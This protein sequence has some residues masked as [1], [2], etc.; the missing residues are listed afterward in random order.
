MPSWVAACAPIRRGTSLTSRTI[1][2]TRPEPG[3]GS[4]AAELARAGHRPILAPFLTVRACRV[5]LPAAAGLQAVVAASGNATAL[6]HS[7]R[8]LPLLA[9]GDATAARARA[10][11]FAVV[12]SA[13]GDAT[14]L[15]ALAARLLR[16]EQGPILLATGRGQG[17]RL[18]A[19]LRHNG[20]TVHRRAVYCA[21]A[22]GRFPPTV[23]DAIREG[24]DV[25]LF[26]S[27]ETARAFAHL[28]PT[29]LRE[30][31][32]RTD[33]VAIG[34]AAADELQHLPWRALRVALRPTQDEVLALL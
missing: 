31:L 6:P 32:G 18:A 2:V 26:F 21:S 20:F 29:G 13:D 25:A 11:G 27:A 5:R 19:A 23:R 14:A 8:A 7:H 1:L 3:G 12:H 10:A 4:T 22:I 9:V 34:P 33:A 28:L 24:L 30:A 16:P 17:T 15:T